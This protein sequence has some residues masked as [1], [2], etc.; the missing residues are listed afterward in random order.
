MAGS[1]KEASGVLW[2]IVYLV[3]KIIVV[4]GPSSPMAGFRLCAGAKAS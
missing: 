3:R 4:L 1:K 2:Y